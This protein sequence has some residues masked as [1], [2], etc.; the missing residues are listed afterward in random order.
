MVTN[1]VNPE[2][3]VIVGGGIG[4]LSAA[5]HLRIAG[6]SV[7]VLEQNDRVGGRASLLEVD[8]FRFDTGPSLVNYPWVFEELFA[9]AGRDF[10]RAVQ[11]LPVEPSIEFRWPDHERLS[12]SSD[13]VRLTSEF[14]RIDP[15]ARVGLS[16]YLRDAQEKYELVFKKLVCRNADSALR[17]FGALTPREMWKLSLHRSLDSELRRFFRNDRIR[18]A[19]GAYGMY[20]GGSPFELPGLFSILAYGELAYGLWLPKGGVYAIIE[21]LEALARELGASIVTGARVERVLADHGR[22]SGVLMESCETAPAD[23]VVSNVDVPT[24]DTS[25][26]SEHLPQRDRR[27]SQRLRMTPG[28]I[29]FYWGLNRAVS[30]LGHHTIFLPR[31]YRRSFSELTKEGVIPSGLPFYTSIP[32]ATDPDLAP[33]GKSAMFVL[34]PVPTLASLNPDDWSATVDGVR[35]QVLERMGAHEMP[36]ER[37][38]IAVERVLTPSDWRRG[39]GLYDGSAFGAAHTLLQMGPFRPSNR[40]ARL[41]GMYYVGASTVPGTGLPMAVLSGKLV[42]ERIVESV[43]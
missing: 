20:L 33:E 12:L 37:K 4:G 22:V 17:W 18:Q 34:V 26:M 42:A 28:V 2:S 10:S 14:E 5:I 25:L 32:S 9:S 24:T 30:E 23:I 3:V 6:F 43:R 35:G 13:L 7:T 36:L 21:A 8:G 15:H 40:S 29:T 31:D 11:L 16:R 38:D 39:F 19:L 1:R 27:R 41:R